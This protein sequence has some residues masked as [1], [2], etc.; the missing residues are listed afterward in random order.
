MFGRSSAPTRDWET[1]KNLCNLSLPISGEKRIRKKL[2]KTLYKNKK[3]RRCWFKQRRSDTWWSNLMQGISPLEFWKKNLRLTRN[4][5]FNLTYELQP[6]ISPI[7]SSPNHRALNADKK[8]ALTSHYLKDTG[9]LI[10]TANNFSYQ[11]CQF[12]YLWSLFGNLSEFRATILF[13]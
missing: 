7:L 10:M 13:A 8:L 2:I 12:C 1:T 6:Y 11:H 4:K 3:K 5:F 9:S